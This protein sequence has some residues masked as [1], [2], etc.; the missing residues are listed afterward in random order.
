[1][2][3]EIISA[4]IAAGTSIATVLIFKPLIDKHL[5]KFSLRQNYIFEQSKKVQNHIALHKSQLLKSAEL[6]NN[7]MKNY[8]KNYNEGWLNVNGNYKIRNHYIDTTVYRFLTFF[9][10]IHLIENGLIYID[11]TISQKRDIRM[12]KYFRI[13]HD[14]MC[15]VELF[16]GYNYDQDVAID[17]FFT[18]PFYDLS[19]NLIVDGRVI[20]LDTF[21]ERKDEMLEKIG[22]VYAFFDSM[23]PKEKRL[24]CERIKIFHLILIAFLNEYGY[25]YQRTSSDTLKLLKEELGAYKLLNNFKPM[26]RKY[27]LNRMFGEIEK[28]IKIVG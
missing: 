18:T 6:L 13:F 8:A 4:L 5:L 12:L 2:N 28:I 1:M 9:A 11:T 3:E 27:R 22:D 19:K 16:K 24:R 20:D 25:D 17:H 26:I 10:Q 23:H 7:R 14:V 21:W 15:D